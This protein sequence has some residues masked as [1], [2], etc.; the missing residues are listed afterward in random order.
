GLLY[1]QSDMQDIPVLIR[2]VSGNP[3]M[4]YSVCPEVI[5]LSGLPNGIYILEIHGRSQQIIL[6]H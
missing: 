6:Q 4:Q 5:D 3:V 2:N 1:L